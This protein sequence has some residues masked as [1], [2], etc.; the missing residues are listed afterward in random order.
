MH[1]IAATDDGVNIYLGEENQA[2]FNYRYPDYYLK[3][4]GKIELSINDREITRISPGGY[5]EV[6]KVSFGNTRK[7]VI[8]S[9]ASGRL[10]K[11]YFIGK[12][13]GNYESEGK[14]W[15]SD[16][17]P[18]IVRESGV[19]AEYRVNTIYR[20]SGMSG[21]LKEIENI[22][23]YSSNVRN[24][25]FEIMID[26]LVLSSDDLSRAIPAMRIIRSN[27]TKGTLMRQIIGKYHLSQANVLAVLKT[28]ETLDYNTEKGS[29]L[30]MIN[31]YLT[32]SEIQL[33]SYF[34]IIESI[35]K[36]SEKGTVLRNLMQIRSLKEDTFIR[37][38]RSLE[39]CSSEREK[40]AVLMSATNYMPFTDR[41]IEAYTKAVEEIDPKYTVLRS[42]VLDVLIAKQTGTN[43]LTKGNKSIIIQLLSN[44]QKYSGN[45]P[46]GE[47]LRRVN[48]ML[49]MDADVYRAYRECYRSMNAVLEQYN[50]L[51]DLLEVQ[52]NLDKNGYL[53]L[54]E[55]TYKMAQ[56]DKQHTVGAVHRYMLNTMPVDI[57]LINAY[58]KTIDIMDQNSTIEEILRYINTNERFTNNEQ[59]I[60]KTIESVDRISV[61]IE[62]A[63]V[64]LLVRSK[65]KTSEQ[66]TAYRYT[67]KS[68]QSDYLKRRVSLDE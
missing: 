30:R 68:I 4:S 62:K 67:V 32:E 18:Q 34:N 16:I 44:A 28:T 35:T 46:K 47:A 33:D 12:R 64:L 40:G 31:P 39:S 58:F 22:E 37:I 50:V 9:D 38:F 21:L 1:L 65:V 63:S 27:S 14:Q 13:V 2:Q 8:V 26:Q 36:N 53:L 49:I 25:Y 24:L 60:L 19:G 54:L 15:L 7:I 5:F 23:R 61:D 55:A 57:D 43:K 3:Y 20:K 45:S 52:K 11:K 17:L 48:R 51:L 42:E 29:V 59:V 10:T 41:V 56:D 66:K 6:S